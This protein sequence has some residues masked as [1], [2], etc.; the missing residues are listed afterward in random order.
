MHDKENNLNAYED[1]AENLHRQ[2]TDLVKDKK[3]FALLNELGQLYFTGSYALDL[4]TWKDIDMQLVLHEGIAPKNALMQA[5]DIF[6]QQEGFN[7]ARVLNCTGEYKPHWP[8]GYCLSS[9]CSFPDFGGLWKFDLWILEKPV[10]D[11]GQLLLEQLKSTMT[12]Q[13]R[14]LILEI[15]HELMKESGRVPQM[16]SHWLYQAILVQGFSEKRAIYDFLREKG[17]PIE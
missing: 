9:K 14:K 6:V 8:R 3:I 13:T 5:L 10:V 1:L 4:M 16:G 11:R 12:D 7:D 15:K 17:I 2:A